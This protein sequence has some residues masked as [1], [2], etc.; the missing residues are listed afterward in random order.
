VK[1]KPT[2]FPHEEKPIFTRVKIFGVVAIALVFAGTLGEI[3]SQKAV[4][5]SRSRG[6]GFEPTSLESS[7]GTGIALGTL[8]GFRTVLADIAW[9][10]AFH[11]WEKR[12][13]AACLK[14]SQLAMTLSPEQFFFLENTANY[15]AFDFPVWE[16]GRRGGTR[17]VAKS[18]RGEIHR[19]AMERALELLADAE[20]NF[21]NNPKI[22]LLAAQIVAFKTE[23]IFGEVDYRRSAEFYRRACELDG[24]PF[25]AFA[26]YTKFVS[27]HIPECRADAENFLKRSRDNEKKPE[28]KRFFD[29]LLGEFFAKENP[30]ITR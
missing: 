11:F 5:E 4:A 26:I 7:A 1:R 22:P 20:K 17:L 12:E 9:L 28:K 29:E 14:F 23:A 24:A 6:G 15:I 21:P 13:P 3:F 27:E 19:Q 8:G 10:R 30:P 16:I 18:V 2:T 25:F